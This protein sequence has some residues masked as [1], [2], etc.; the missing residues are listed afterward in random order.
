VHEI[1]RSYTILA[2]ASAAMFERSSALGSPMV[3]MCAAV[4]GTPAELI[5][6]VP[7]P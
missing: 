7:A 4:Q 6:G 5:S 3:S 2:R 1:R